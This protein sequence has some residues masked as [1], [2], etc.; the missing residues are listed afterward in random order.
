VFNNQTSVDYRTDEGVV[1]EVDAIRKVYK[2][3]TLRGKYLS[4]VYR[5][6]TSGSSSRG[7]L[8]ETLQIGDRVMVSWALG[9][10]IILGTLPKMQSAD[11]GTPLS[12]DG[13]NGLVDTGNFT[14]EGVAVIGD[15]NAPKD[16]LVGDH[17]IT[18]EGGGLIAALRGGTVVFRAS[19]LAEII[20][21]KFDD[22]IRVV[23]R[24]WQHFTD[25]HSDVVYNL[26]GRVFRYSGYATSFNKGKIEDYAWHQYFG[27]T[28]AAE[29]VKSDF[30]K[31]EVS[32]AKTD[33]VYKEQLKEE[34]VDETMRRTVELDGTDETVVVR[35]RHTQKVDSHVLT[36]NEVNTVT[37]DPN[38]IRID[39]NGQSFIELTANSVYL[40]H[41]GGTTTMDDAGIRSEFSG[42]FVRIN[43]SGVHLG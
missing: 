37:I 35:T 34:G 7:G 36:W 29:E 3:R 22:L 26:K 5:L 8:R 21:S 19:R 2:V 24:N 14:G 23:S 16:M 41:G 10:P 6:S 38:K 39:F 30:A 31:K 11:E 32:A 4:S 43:S 25:L 27:D 1:T 17:V 13:G 12:I 15:Q 28:S 20:A 42:H 18:S 9:Y 40:E 33:I